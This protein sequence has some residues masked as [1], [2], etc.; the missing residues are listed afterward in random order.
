MKIR[1]KRA[2]KG[3]VITLFLLFIAIGAWAV[4][5]VRSAW[6]QVGGTLVARGLAAPVEVVRDRWGIP[7]IYAANEHDL[8]FA[9]GYVH[10]QDRLWQMHFNRIV[11]SGR[12]SSLFGPATLGPDRYLRTLGLRRAA[13]RDWALLGAETRG[14]L[15]AYASGVNAFLAAHRGALPVEFALLGVEPEPWTPLDSLT[16]SRT[17]SLNLSLNSGIELLRARLVAALGEARARLLIPLDTREGPFIVSGRA[18]GSNAWA[19]HGSRTE[20]GMPLLANDTHL[21]LGMPSV[22][23]EN[24]LHGGRFDDVGFSFPGMPFVVLGQNRRIAWGITNLNADVQDVYREKLD[25]PK[26]PTRA[27]F[28][29]RWE[30]LSL[31]R[32]TIAVKGGKPVILEVRSTRHGPLIHE[33]T[34]DWKAA[35]PIAMRWAASE[36]SRLV[37]A[38]ADLDR[39][40]SWQEFR[41]ALSRW[42]TPSL[43]FVYADVAG[44][45]GYQSTARVPLRAPGHDGSV[46][47]PGWTGEYEW[48]G[49]IPFE[50]MPQV[51]NPAAG[52][53]VTA[54]N[55]VAGP[56]YP[57]LL[58]MDWPPA[59]RA[60]RIT[61]LL[62]G[63][64]RATRES[65]ARFQGDTYSAVAAALRPYLKAVRPQSPLE[66]DALAR[67]MAWDLRFDPGEVGP[68]IY[69]AWLH[70]LLPDTFMNE[71]GAE[72]T[73]DAAPLVYGQSGMLM[74]LMAHP[75]DPWFDD[76]RTPQVEGRD[77]V[78]RRSFSQAI[79]W[80]AERQGRSPAEWRWGRMHT[81]TFVHQP[82]GMSGIA[83]LERMFNSRSLA[84]PGADE[85]VNSNLSDPEHPFR[86]TFGVSQR[87]I[88]DLSDLSRSLA[89][90]STGQSGNLFHRHRED[91]APMWAR[92]DYHPV[93]ASREAVLRNAEAVLRPL[94]R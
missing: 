92:G 17:M 51:L 46:P 93:L 63:E 53:V 55:R 4:W 24:G 26:R 41:Q 81:M 70:F 23:Y 89:I 14:F 69:S 50:A 84:A 60:R 74:D 11:G 56:D 78:V 54:N 47:V 59:D 91:Q 90:N 32:E 68:T 67:A 62:A 6:P 85:T 49:Y 34:P 82:L 31:V 29:G 15:T 20:S 10:A 8:F 19:V 3:A 18:W 30:P 16:W 87:Y 71:M 40:H 2:L 21:G 45:I 80:L 66:A 38:L 83:P 13:A 33:V 65:M 39:A 5:R 27:E 25:D 57:Y 42:D 36:G 86:V 43:N 76:R 48:R 73:K 12:L 28:Q 79:A 1:L 61:A 64:R 75:N 77:D 9:Q 7:H 35:E 58:T 44:N 22:W 88:A 94:P 72:L 37:D 52:F